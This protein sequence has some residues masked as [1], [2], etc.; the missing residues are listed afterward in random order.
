MVFAIYIL[1]MHTTIC[2]WHDTG[3]SESFIN[4][5]ISIQDWIE[6]TVNIFNQPG[7]ELQFIH[8][9]SNR[10]SSCQP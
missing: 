1:H 3:T 2:C 4:S 5:T 9:T 8:V 10:Y 7:I 6:L